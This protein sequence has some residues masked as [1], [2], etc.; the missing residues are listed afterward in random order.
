VRTL[1]RPTQLPRPWLRYAA[2][3]CTS[4]HFCAAVD[5]GARAMTWDGSAWSTAT[6]LPKG[7]WSNLVCTSASS[8]MAI[9]ATGESVSQVLLFDGDTWTDAGVVT[10][11]LVGALDCPAA[12]VCWA[13]GGAGDVSRYD[14]VGWSVPQQIVG[15]TDGDGL[16]RLSWMSCPTT[17]SCA[18][19]DQYGGLYRLDGTVWST[20]TVDV[21]RRMG[22]LSCATGSSCTVVDGRSSRAV[23][24]FDGGG[25]S[26]PQRFVPRGY[27]S[28]TTGLSCPTPAFCVAVDTNGNAFVR[29]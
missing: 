3:S 27:D 16:N 20:S 23:R 13:G 1:D 19:H 18:T 22:P 8:C 26:S 15:S 24:R 12:D 25:W 2:V 9:D 21:T 7:R 6:Q 28:T 4:A 17:T 14:G 5:A 29:Q 11:G 10:L